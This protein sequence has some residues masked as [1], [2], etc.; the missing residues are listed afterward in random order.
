[1]LV[2]VALMP[3]QNRFSLQFHRE[4][5]NMYAGRFDSWLPNGW[6]AQ[7]YQCSAV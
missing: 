4:W 2:I 3:S 6:R 7:F 1:M 5:H